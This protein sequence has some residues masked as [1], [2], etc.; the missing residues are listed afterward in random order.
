MRRKVF[1]LIV[2]TGGMLMV[3]VLLAAGA[4]LMWA[5]S[6]TQSTVHDQLAQQQIYFPTAAQI[7]SAPAS[8]TEIPPSAKPYL[9]PYAGQEVLTG[10]QAETYANH[11]IGVHLSAMPYGGVYSKVST[12]SRANPK[13]TALSAEVQTSFQ[14]TTLRAMLLEAYGFWTFGEI[15]FWAAIVSFI[16]AFVMAVLVGFGFWHARR[17]PAEAELL[18][19]RTEP[20]KPQAGRPQTA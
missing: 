4:L 7:Q 11:Y 10:P 5:Y 2:S 14:G 16:G 15:A 6:F 12:A 1:D 3:V 20:P 13:D 18:A 19:A 17:T 8:S 9:L